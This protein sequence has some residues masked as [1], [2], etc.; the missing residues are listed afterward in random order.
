MA[1]R[2]AA[3]AL[4]FCASCC[5]YTLVGRAPH[6]A[7]TSA[8]PLLRSTRQFPRMAEAE[9]PAAEGAPPEP[10]AE[11]SAAPPPPA[12]DAASDE[13]DDLLSS[14]AF[15]KQK[16]KV[17]EKELAEVAEKTVEAKERAAEA[18]AEF[19]QKRTRLQTDFDN[20]RAR[21]YNQT[22]DAQV[23]ARIKL[24]SAFLPVLD[25]FDRARDSISPNGEEEEAVNAEYQAMHAM[26]MKA[27]EELEV[28]KIPTVGE[29]FDY[30][31]HNAI[32]QVWLPHRFAIPASRTQMHGD[33][34]AS[35]SRRAGTV[36]RVRGGHRVL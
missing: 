30:N 19:S 10:S 2:A 29:E 24:L 15:L 32:Q 16:L 26:L 28:T 34:S 4:L 36:G 31:L 6:P 18:R 7:V 27:L 11:S 13:G 22:I 35:E 3:L 23:D 8:A 20:F 17:L 14:P 21:H 12:K 25:N 1:R 9:E 33:L 5:C